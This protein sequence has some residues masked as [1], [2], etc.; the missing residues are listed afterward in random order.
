M[1]NTRE[2]SIMKISTRLWLT[3]ILIASL[4]GTACSASE[5]GFKSHSFETSSG[6][7]VRAELGTFSVPE[8]RT[9]EDSRTIQL[10]FVRFKSTSKNPGSPIVYLAGGP[11]GSGIDTAKGTRFP[12]FMAMREFGDVIALDQRGT[13]ISGFE[14]LDCDDRYLI[15]LDQPMDRA[16]AG[17]IIADATRGCTDQLRGSGI[18]LDA[19]NTRENAADLDALRRF[20]GAEKITLWG[21]SY[22]THL[23]LAAL[24]YHGK[25]IDRVILAGVEGP[26]HTWKLPSD[27]QELME[28]IARLSGSDPSVAR[29]LPDLLGS[30]ER[31]MSELDG[32]PRSVHLTH[33]LNGEE[34]EVRVGKFD[35]QFAISNM[36]RGPSSFSSMPDAIARIANGDWTVLALASAQARI[37]EGLHGMS[38]AMDCASGAGKE[39]RE[40]IAQEAEGTLLGDAINFP[41]PEVCHGQEITD[42]GDAYRE[43]VKSDAPTLVI[44][45]TLDGRTPVKNGEEVLPGLKNAHHLIIDGAGH[46]D[47]LFLSSPKILQAMQAFMRGQKI[48][49][50]RIQLPAIKFIAPRKIVDLDDDLLSRYVGSYRIAKGDVRQVMKAGDLLYTQRGR[51]QVLPIRPTA[52]TEFFYEG[53]GDHLSFQT[54]AKGKVTGML[55]YYAGGSGEGVPAKR[56]R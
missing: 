16:K 7:K 48:P 11:G 3:L 30:L 10:K 37:G 36:L 23:A 8:N 22:G 38:L 44:S 56:V 17:K 19:Y 6:E 35:L 40:R 55:M 46:S 25:Q 13:G 34:M 12:L 43:P 9:K 51:G 24:K 1:T 14:E 31:I 52:A 18:D 45:G 15:P 2:D 50:E 54:D 47:P 39:W 49:Y 20:L 4:T 41:F 29:V 28:E 5:D 26:R 32:K 27:Q 33:P 21:I 42:L 53:S